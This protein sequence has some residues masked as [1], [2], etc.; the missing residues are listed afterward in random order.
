MPNGSIVN[1]EEKEEKLKWTEM[2]QRRKYKKYWVYTWKVPETEVKEIEEKG[3]KCHGK[4]FGTAIV[5][6]KLLEIHHWGLET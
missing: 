2:S 3:E 5:W 1:E 6:V 4:E